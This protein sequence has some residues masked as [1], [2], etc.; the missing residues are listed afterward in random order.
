M[1]DER[2]RH[3]FLDDPTDDVTLVASVLCREVAGKEQLLKVV[4]AGGAQ[5]LSQTPL[6]SRRRRSALLR[7]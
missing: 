2:K 6:P 7:I 4:K 5:Y 3:P 1:S